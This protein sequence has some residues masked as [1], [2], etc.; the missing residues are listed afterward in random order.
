MLLSE[1]NYYLL[2]ILITIEFYSRFLFSR[3][4]IIV[5]G[6]IESIVDVG[7]NLIDIR[8]AIHDVLLDPNSEAGKLD[9]IPKSISITEPSESLAPFLIKR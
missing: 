3:G 7:E 1:I 8:D 9:I 6:R 5:K 4:S 2:L